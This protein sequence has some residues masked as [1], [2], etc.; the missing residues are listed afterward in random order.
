MANVLEVLFKNSFLE[1]ALGFFL[2]PVGTISP[3]KKK[4]AAVDSDCFYAY[5]KILSTWAAVMPSMDGW[6]GQMD[7]KLHEKRP[8]RLLLYVIVQN[9][10]SIAI[11]WLQK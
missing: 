6:T 11:C 9:C 10:I 7:E 2:S 8:R 1:V 4:N 3:R 5:S